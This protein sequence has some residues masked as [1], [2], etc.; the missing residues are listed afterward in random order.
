[1]VTPEELALGKREAAE[2][3]KLLQAGDNDAWQEFAEIC[4]L[5]L[6]KVP[7][8]KTTM[9]FLVLAAADGPP[10]EKSKE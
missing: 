8:A 3:L 5:F 6:R 1:V 10:K 9:K 2:F 4:R 7:E